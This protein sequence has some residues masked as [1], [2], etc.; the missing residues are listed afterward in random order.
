MTE[1]AENSVEVL[2]SK[3]KRMKRI[4]K[5]INTAHT[6]IRFIRE[7]LCSNAVKNTDTMKIKTLRREVREYHV[8]SQTLKTWADNNCLLE[9]TDLSQAE[10]NEAFNMCKSL[11][12]QIRALGK[13]Y[14]SIKSSNLDDSLN[15]ITDL[16]DEFRKA[17]SLLDKANNL[18]Y[19]IKNG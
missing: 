5:H 1:N 3:L 7:A 9:R 14:V 12:M 10:A 6:S 8:K 19:G 15:D 16:T 17:F 18:I 11:N 2:S 13:I 4:S